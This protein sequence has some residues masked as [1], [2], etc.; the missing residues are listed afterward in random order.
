MTTPTNH[1]PTDALIHTTHLVRSRIE[2]AT[3]T[4][5]DQL[6]EHTHAAVEYILDALNDLMKQ[7]AALA[8]PHYRGPHYS[9]GRPIR[10][11]IAIPER[12]SVFEHLWP[13]DPAQAIEQ[14][15]ELSGHGTRH[16]VH[17]VPPSSLTVDT[18]RTLT[19][20]GEPEGVEP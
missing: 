3:D 7:V 4:L 5:S 6:D 16:S 9:D 20:V 13:A 18:V 14:H 10:S 2:W 1:T 11:R 19:V 15:I 12:N 17:I 8:R